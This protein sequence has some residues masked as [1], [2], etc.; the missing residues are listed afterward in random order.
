MSAGTVDVLAVIRRMRM[1]LPGYATES[2]KQ[3]DD[4]RDAVAELIAKADAMQ[5][6]LPQ[7]PLSLAHYHAREELIAFREALA[8]VGGGS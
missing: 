7:D 4:A 5:R 8:R 2:L 1:H 3:A 6:K